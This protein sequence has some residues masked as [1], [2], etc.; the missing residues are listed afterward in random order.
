MGASLLANT[1]CQA[2][3]VSTDM[4]PSRAGSLPQGML[5]SGR[6]GVAHKAV[7]F[8]TPHL[9]LRGDPGSADRA[10]LSWQP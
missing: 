1:V 9:V 2:T 10:T 8:E 7:L 4:T 5:V 6:V 3:Q